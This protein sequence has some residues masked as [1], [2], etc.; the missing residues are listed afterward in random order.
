M[1]GEIYNRISVCTGWFG[2]DSKELGFPLDRMVLENWG[3]SIIEYHDNYYVGDMQNKIELIIRA[4]IE[5]KK[6]HSLRMAKR[7]GY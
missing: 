1:L 6:H 2:K 5:I 7:G 3:N 4:K